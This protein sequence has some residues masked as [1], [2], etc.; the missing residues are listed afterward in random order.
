MF[1]NDRQRAFS[2]VF[3]M[4]RCFSRLYAIASQLSPV[5][6]S[7]GIQQLETDTFKLHCFQT[8]TG[9]KTHTCVDYLY[10]A[11][12]S[13][14]F[15]YRPDC[16]SKVTICTAVNFDEYSQWSIAITTY[17]GFLSQKFSA[18]KV[19][20]LCSACCIIPIVLHFRTI[21]L[22]TTC[23]LYI[24]REGSSRRSGVLID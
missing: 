10:S 8:L 20:T 22:D 21:P 11:Q 12:S 7:T 24:S 18:E 2:V 1:R 4:W 13:A 3:N 23:I 9:K 15:L 16:K 5:Q 6:H 14:D 17:N 19:S